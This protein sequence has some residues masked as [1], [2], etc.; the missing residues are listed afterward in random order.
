MPEARTVWQPARP[1]KSSWRTPRQ[2]SACACLALAACGGTGSDPR[3]PT[4]VLSTPVEVET[5]LRS[6]IAG[7]ARGGS[8]ERI[9]LEPALVTFRDRRR[10]DD[11]SRLA[12][13]LLAWIALEKGDLERAAA[14][15]HAIRSVAGPG[16]PGTA[17]DIAAAVEGAALRRLGHPEQ[18]LALLSPLV[19]KLIDPWARSL[20]NQE[21]VGSA[22]EAGRW[23]RALGLMRVWL[24]EAG[25]EERATA[26][27]TVER[28]LESAPPL[29]LLSLLDSGSRAA[30]PIADEEMEMRKLVARRL[31]SVAQ[32]HRDAG[33]AQHLL[34][35]AGGA[36]GDRGEIVAQLAAGADRARVEARTV[37]LVVSLRNDQTRRRGADIA[38]GVSFG[39]GL[40]GS[41]ARLVSRDDHGSPERLEEAL[42][43]LSADGASIIIVGSD[44]QDAARAAAFAEA[45]RIPVLLLRPPSGEIARGPAGF[46]FVL[47][48][49]PADLEASLIAALVARGAGPVAIL[50]E[51]PGRPRAPRPDVVGL[52]GCDEARSPW[53]GVGAA[54][55]VLSA[56]HDCARDAIAAAEPLKLR[57]AVGF[58]AEPL[59]LPTGS[60]MATAG[61]FPFGATPPPPI[62]GWLRT[63]PNPPSWWAALGHDAAVLAWAGVQ[64]LPAQG[65]EDPAEVEARRAQAAATLAAARA[66]LWTTDA[67]GFHG[68]RTLP[69]T[70]GVR[71]ITSRGRP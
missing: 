67:Q 68:T 45:H 53:Q 30:A 1:R 69:R 56:E 32:Q 5:E 21:S 43:A 19:S 57:F 61:V 42:A 36:L 6:L 44:E 33:L 49:D 11:G 70:I 47:G 8:A 9:A 54:G 60:V 39:L 51:Q 24:R 35:T 48:A 3:A 27:A 59:A 17:S 22:V 12:D 63:H 15:A 62:E 10:E 18:A 40:P 71:E 34:A 26:R 50:S 65:T 13:V 31:A 14:R 7:W 66:E 55:V 25:A 41:A 29:E 16:T 37:G 64:V 4:A 28:D 46:A 20:C 38:E 2:W 52:R 58:E 23:G